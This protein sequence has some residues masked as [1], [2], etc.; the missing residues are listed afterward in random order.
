MLP[1]SS[2]EERNGRSSELVMALSSSTILHEGVHG[3][4][5][6]KPGSKF[7]QD[8]ERVSGLKDE[9]G[10]KATL[11]DEGIAYAIQGVYAPSVEPLGSLSPIPRDDE[12]GEVKMRKELGVR[13]R[14]KIEEY[15]KTNRQMDDELLAFASEQ[16]KILQQE[17][18]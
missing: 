13:L 18:I 11:L 15:L 1:N 14:P 2:E 10:S 12:R 5:D 3:L 4:L 6:S 8:L 9:S 7:A 17:R 16:L